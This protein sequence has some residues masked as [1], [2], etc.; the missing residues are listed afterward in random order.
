ML[1]LN[2]KDD[3]FT[4]VQRASAMPSTRQLAP[5]RVLAVDATSVKSTHRRTSGPCP[6]RV[7]DREPRGQPGG[8][9]RPRD[10][11]LAHR[12]GGDQQHGAGQPA[13]VSHG[14]LVVTIS[15]NNQVSQPNP[16]SGGRT[17]TTAHRTSPS[18]RRV[19]VV[20]FVFSPGVTLDSVVRAV[21]Q[22]GAG[23]SDLVAILEALK[24]A[25]ALK[26]DLV[27]I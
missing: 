2:L 9:G 20:A 13:A 7:D 23:P 1:T 27:V 10:R 3:D 6:V 18:R 19:I 26:A 12:H 8:I 24:Q 14:N 17:V 22:V 16:L 25:G 4:T 11:Q 21:N 5:Y 15:E